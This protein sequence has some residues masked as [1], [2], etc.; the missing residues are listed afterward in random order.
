MLRSLITG[1]ILCSVTISISSQEPDNVR[2]LHKKAD[3]LV[4]QGNYVAALPILQKLSVAEPQNPS[5]HFQLGFAYLSKA[6]LSNNVREKMALRKRGRAEF[7]KAKTLGSKESVVDALIESIPSDGSLPKKRKPT[8]ADKAMK[9]AENAF[10]QGKNDEALKYYK[11]AHK[12]NPILYTA[13]LYVGDVYIRLKD[14]TN[15]E[16]WY[17]KAISI[18]PY[19]ETAYRYSATPLMKMNKHD[20]A[21]KR[22]VEAYI[23]EPYSKYATAGLT[24]WGRVTS[25]RL[26]HP[27]V[28]VPVSKSNKNGKP[29]TTITVN[30]TQDGSAAWLGYTA[31][32]ILWKDS[33]F[34]KTFPNE[35]R[36]RHSLKEEAE[37]FRSAIRIAKE[38]RTKG[39][40]LNTE[41]EVLI[42]LDKK[43]LLEAFILM[44]KPDRGIARDHANYIR[45]NRSNLRRYVMDYVIVKK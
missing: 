28:N 43:G 22:Y 14:F 45:S 4:E 19:R 32:R 37:A 25:T 31:T 2:E 24:N 21:L 20:E 23:V 12:L 9:N 26:G 16:I 30:P 11:K 29:L 10:A 40:K 38:L 34:S 36:Y 3:A 6:Q 7:V 5:V 39:T 1:L 35:R 41:L 27:R 18:N 42:E 13:P 17:Q 15:A 44:A 8:P 33:K